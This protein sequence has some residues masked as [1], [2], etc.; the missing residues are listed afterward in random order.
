MW[1]HFLF[2]S[3]GIF[4]CDLTVL[5]R[6]ITGRVPVRMYPGPW[7]CDQCSCRLCLTTHTPSLQSVLLWVVLGHPISKKPLKYTPPPPQRNSWQSSLNVLLAKVPPQL[8]RILTILSLL[9]GCHQRWGQGEEGNKISRVNVA[10]LEWAVV[11]QGKEY[12]TTGHYEEKKKVYF[13]Q[14]LG[15]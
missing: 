15:V 13:R 9:A 4:S 3:S 12:I 6:G 14:N 2:P 1:L 10:T 11:F 8:P 5:F 7:H